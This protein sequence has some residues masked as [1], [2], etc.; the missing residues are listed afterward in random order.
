M[1]RELTEILDTIAAMAASAAGE[2]SDAL[3]A[4]QWASALVGTWQVGPMPEPDADRLFGVGLVLALERIGDPGALAALRALAAIGEESYAPRAHQAAD[5]LAGAGVAEPPWLTGLGR[6]EPVAA[7][8]MCED[9]GFD[10]GLSVMVEF[11]TPGAES[12]T[13]GIYIDRNLGGL[14][15]D[16]FVAGPLASVREQLERHGPGRHGLALR[17]LDL[18]QARVRVQDALEILDHTFDPPVD[19]DVRALRALMRAR[20]R[21]LPERDAEEDEKH[22]A[23]TSGERAQLLVDF[24]DSPE[25]QRWRGCEDAEDAA[26]L[27]IDFGADYNHGGALRWSPV[28]VEIFMTDWL[29]RKVTR[30]PQF[31]ECVPDVLRDW[32]KFAGHRR[33]VPAAALRQAVAAVKRFRKEMLQAVDDPEAWGPAKAFAVAAQQAGVDLSDADALGAFVERHNED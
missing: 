3:D 33:G 12:H 32:V 24:L 2:P 13:L 16:A 1:E 7:L 30:E 27:A 29:A 21:T 28:V 14:V 15:K 18:A 8:V 4:E 17:E 19:E 6:A 10:D 22:P 31:F 20:I 11:A 23:V 5:L 25:G 9:D 26:R